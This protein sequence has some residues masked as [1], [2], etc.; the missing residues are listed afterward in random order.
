[1]GHNGCFRSGFCDSRNMLGRGD[2]GIYP[3][4]E[5]SIRT[6]KIW[7]CDIFLQFPVHGYEY[8]CIGAFYGVFK[9]K[10]I[11]DT[12]VFENICIFDGLPAFS[13][14][15]LGSGWNMARGT[16]CGSDGAFRIGLLSGQI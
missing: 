3:G 2:N 8:F 1:M 10:G 15:V 9:W 7:F 6:D 13:A 12:V 5:R 16:G 4:R 14:A 11:C